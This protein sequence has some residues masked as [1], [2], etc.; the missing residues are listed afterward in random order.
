VK[1]TICGAL[2]FVL[3]C[4]AILPA[5][6][7][8]NFSQFGNETVEFI[9]QPLHW[10]GNDWLRLGL[11]TAGTVLVM[12]L[13]QPVR[14]AMLKDRGYYKSFPI[15]FGRR[16]GD[17]FTTIA[18][19]GGFALHG[20]LAGNRST[21]KVAFEI[22]QSALY[23]G[24][25]TAALKLALGRA[26]PFTNRGA[27]VYQPFTIFDDAY[28]SL[29]S[30][31]TTLAFALSTVL[32]RNAGSPPLKII[33]FLPAALTALSRVYQDYHWASDCVLAG[34]IGYA[35]A[36]WVVDR[37]D[38]NESPVSVSSVFPLTIRIVLN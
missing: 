16:W 13:D 5:Q 7:R 35:V 1:Q 38:R 17:N 31:H 3:S 28:Y 27:F 37:H 20:I 11:A 14:D 19:A 32:S 21:R 22:A 15:E 36:T 2:I 18:A 8:F 25:I 33:A 23:A 4:T 26:R 24:G 34:I 6:N 12:Q 10:E 29:P 9:R 30:G